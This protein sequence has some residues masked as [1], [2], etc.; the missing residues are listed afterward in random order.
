M[1]KFAL[2]LSILFLSITGNPVNAQ[3][4]FVF[5]EGKFKICQFTD[6]HWDES[7]PKYN[8]TT[9]TILS[10]LSLEKPALAVLSGD[11][12]TSDPALK[13]WK[14]IIR[15][16]EDAKMPFVVTLGNHDGEVT[17]KD[18]IFQ[19]LLAS[20]YYAGGRGL[21]N[22]QGYGN[23]VIPV[24]D[25]KTKKDIRALLYFIDTNDY[26]SEKMYG[27]YDWIHFD[28]IKW[29]RQQSERY[30]S[31]NKNRP[32]PAIVYLHIPLPEYNDLV[33]S[34]TYFGS[35]LEGR[36]SS[37]DVNSG[38]FAA[39][40]DM[41][42]VMGVFAGH[43]HDN[44]FIG[45]HKGVT[46][47]Y[48]RVTGAAAY[49][50]LKRGARTVELHEG[51]RQFD[52]W[53][54]TP[55]GKELKFYFPSGITSD[56]ETQMTYL[57]AKNVNPLKHGVAYTYYEGIFDNTTQIFAGKMIKKGTIPDFSIGESEV[58]DHFGFHFRSLMYIPEKGVYR[59]FIYSDDG[60]RLLIDGV[61][62][63]DNDGG[64]SARRAEGKVALEKGFHELEVLYFED[65]MGE[66]LEV[67]ILGRNLPETLLK[68]EMLYLPD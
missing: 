12:V 6:F 11:V 13:G 24:Y 37:S 20:P 48:G 55:A 28:Q 26:P 16:F 1:N 66:T 29:F 59:F 41:K 22:I 44:D 53:I 50:T 49:G 4:K 45:I 52:T 25:S 39:L 9:A 38:F 15:L 64:H 34:K 67:G 36:S 54:T 3:K 8:E 18:S 56:D 43:D 14:S 47:G 2:F 23:G 42:D 58:K 63:V 57:P 31:A 21:K 62:V 68:D 5:T 7:S 65:Y 30:T 35:N 60:S 61:Q 32:Y 19:L 17:A 33:T 40:L 51:K 46:L 10:V 27:N